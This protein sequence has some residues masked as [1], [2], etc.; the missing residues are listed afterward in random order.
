MLIKYE[1]MVKE[2]RTNMRGGEGEVFIT[3]IAEK[4]YLL[5]SRLMAFITIPKGASIGKHDHNKEIEYFIILKGEGLVVE[6]NNEYKVKPRDVVITGGGSSHSIK[7]CG[8][9]DLEMIAVI[10]T[11]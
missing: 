9:E 7:N 4:D 8:K 6:D 2:K 11:E 10:I 1:N 5:H 3:H